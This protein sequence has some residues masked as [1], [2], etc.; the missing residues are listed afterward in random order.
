MPDTMCYLAQ[1]NWFLFSFSGLL[2]RGKN[3]PSKTVSISQSNALCSI[4]P[5]QTPQRL[6]RLNLVWNRLKPNLHSPAG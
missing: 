6:S 5:N 4:N 2:W 1:W 3:E